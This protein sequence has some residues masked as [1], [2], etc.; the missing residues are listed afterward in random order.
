MTVATEALPQ[1][2]AHER[3]TFYE[4]FESKDACLLALCD[5]M[6]QQI[7]AQIAAGY[8]HSADWVAQLQQVTHTYLATLQSRPALLRTLF[9]EL[10]GLGP[11]GLGMRR[12]IQ[13]SFADFL[14]MQVEIARLSEPHKRPLDAPLAMA[15]V[16]GIAELILQ[17]IE[18]QR[19]DRLTDLTPTVTGFVQAVLESL[20][21]LEHRTQP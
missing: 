2:P 17:A 8:D 5:G 21:P 18:E 12:R 4:Q 9:V 13:Q 3:R 1:Q 15:V 16:G 20:V 7:L 6:S 19:A 11:Q 14:R 10:Y